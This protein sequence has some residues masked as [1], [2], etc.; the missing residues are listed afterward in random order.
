MTEAQKYQKKK[1][2]LIVTFMILLLVFVCFIC[3]IF[4][5]VKQ[6]PK[7]EFVSS[8][9]IEIVKMQ[10]KEL[11][12]KDEISYVEVTEA[13]D[14]VVL[15]EEKEKRLILNDNKEIIDSENS[16]KVKILL[17]DIDI[18]NN[19]KMIYQNELGSLILSEDGKLYKLVNKNMTN[20]SL[21]AGQILTN[22]EVK[23]IVTLEVKADS[24]YV[25][26]N[27]NKLI[28]VNTQEEYNRIIKTLETPSG[29]IYIYD[30]NGIALEEGKLFVDSEGNLIKLNIF[31]ENKLI[32]EKSVIYEVD[33]INK[34]ISTS[35]L[36][37]MKQVGYG[38]LEN[39]PY[40][41]RVEANT[42]YYDFKSEYY[43]TR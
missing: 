19:I 12:Q 41:I 10:T 8:D 5:Y 6:H 15:S 42:G 2:A 30:N 36:G 40:S 11:E 37:V 16:Q 9:T 20:A 14:F 35:K 24:I 38:K 3:Y 23:N 13:T 34:E 27:D 25:L 1:N 43:Y 7:K 17:N 22:M 31:F 32:D 26:L 29:N 39:E 4:I 18:N 33:F 28:N 21:N